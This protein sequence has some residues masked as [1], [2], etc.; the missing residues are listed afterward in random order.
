MVEQTNDKTDYY[1][2]SLHELGEVLIKEEQTQDMGR[3]ILRLT[4]GTIMASKGAI[5]LYDKEKEI[6]F[7]LATQGF[8]EPGPLSSTPSQ[9]EKLK[10]YS[11]VSYTHLRA[12]E[13]RE[14]RVWRVVV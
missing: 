6:Y 12:H 10:Y 5:F 8:N 2:A 11:P 4:L 9:I 1:L 7:S 13:T 3:G 14:D